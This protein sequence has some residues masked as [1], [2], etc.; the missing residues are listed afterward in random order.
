[1]KP[2]TTLIGTDGSHTENTGV[3][4]TISETDILNGKRGRRLDNITKIKKEG[5]KKQ[6]KRKRRMRKMYLRMRKIRNVILIKEMMILK[7]RI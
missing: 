1:M 2:F 5:G 3:R 4:S 7:K 6:S